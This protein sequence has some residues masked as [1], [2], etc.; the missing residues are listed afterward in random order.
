MLNDSDLRGKRRDQK[1]DRLRDLH[2]TAWR[3]LPPAV[4]FM[5]TGRALKCG[6][7]GAGMLLAG[8]GPRSTARPP[9]DLPP[10]LHPG[11]P[12]QCVDMISAE[13]RWAIALANGIALSRADPGTAA[14]FF[15]GAKGFVNFAVARNRPIDQVGLPDSWSSTLVAQWTSAAQFKSDV[16]S[17]RVPPSVSWVA[18]DIEGWSAT[19]CAEQ[20]DPVSAMIAFGDEARR[21]GLHVLFQPSRDLMRPSA[22]CPPSKCDPV[23]IGVDP[24]NWDQLFIDCRIAESVAPHGDAFQIQA[25]AHETDVPRYHALVDAIHA[26]VSKAP[27]C[28][29]WTQLTTRGHRGARPDAAVLR[30]AFDAVAAETTGL[31]LAIP[32]PEGLPTAVE[33]LRGLRPACLARYAQGSL[34][35][36]PQMNL[37]PA[38]PVASHPSELLPAVVLAGPER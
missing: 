12:G 25:Q 18:Y 24:R 4:A 30:A 35:S 22:G 16:A 21:H 15:G 5:P 11:D 23:G 34:P 33:F 20:A 14:H 3:I 7:V 31:Y 32:D 8:C 29:L 37:R 19:P 17:G 36:L 2:H 1:P 28:E 38:A 6:M 9:I 26:Q 13:R 27:G 10:P